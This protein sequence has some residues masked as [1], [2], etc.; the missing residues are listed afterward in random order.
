[1]HR[2]KWQD[3]FFFACLLFPSSCIMFVRASIDHFTKEARCLSYTVEFNGEG[4]QWFPDYFTTRSILSQHT[5]TY[6]HMSWTTAIMETFVAVP[7]R[8]FLNRKNRLPAFTIAGA[9]ESGHVYNRVSR[10]FQKL[11]H[12]DPLIV[13]RTADSP[14]FNFTK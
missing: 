11:A 1:M 5:H 12:V 2:R 10:S 14:E 3:K 8:L 7:P 4:L 6:T 13:S 9:N